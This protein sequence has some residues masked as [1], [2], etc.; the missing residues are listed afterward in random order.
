MPTLWPWAMT[1]T[2]DFHGQILKLLYLRNGGGADWHGTKEMWVDRML[3][4]H[5]D[6]NF[7]LTHAIDLGFWRSVFEIAL[8]G[9]ASCTQIRSCVHMASE[10]HLQIPPFYFDFPKFSGGEP[11]AFGARRTETPLL[12]PPIILYKLSAYTSFQPS[13]ATGSI[14]GTGGP[15]NMEQKECESIGCYTYYVTLNYDFDLEFWRSNFKKLYHRNKRMDLHGTKRMWVDWMLDPSCDFKV[16]PHPW[17]WP[18]I[19]KV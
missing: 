14:S 4:S 2:L 11:S 9:V 3:D 8:S 15:I 17:H 12:L 6:L 19:F 18:W 5:C 13:Y 7:D 10:K 16:C 1:L